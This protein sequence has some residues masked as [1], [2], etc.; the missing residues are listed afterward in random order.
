MSVLKGGW[1]GLIGGTALSTG[2][3]WTLGRRFPAIRHL[4]PSFHA[5]LVTGTGGFAAI[6]YADRYSRNYEATHNPDSAYT[7]SQIL[8]KKQL[9][10]A[11]PLSQRASEWGLQNR[12]RIVLSSWVK[13]VQAR[14]F[15][16]GS[17]LAVVIASLA[18]E[19]AEDVMNGNAGEVLDSVDR[20]RRERY[21]GQN[22]WMDM[23]AAGEQRIKE[24]EQM[25]M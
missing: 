5:F 24:Q 4:N 17:T 6:I 10:T 20:V 14:V 3:L 13:L 21:P 16:Q 1:G 19:G 2:I 15:A 12:Y 8:L 18:F 22:R 11:K 7:S 25:T 9:Q 23:V